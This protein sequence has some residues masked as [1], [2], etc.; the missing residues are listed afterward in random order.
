MLP[1]SLAW[2]AETEAERE[3][4]VVQ[5]VGDDSSLTERNRE[6]EQHENSDKLRLVSVSDAPDPYSPPVAGSLGITAEFEARPTDAG[7]G[8]AR[9]GKTF[10]IRVTVTV[11][12][13]TDACRSASSKMAPAVFFGLVELGPMTPAAMV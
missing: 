8:N 11:S 13:V 9:N 7:A 4:H 5:N 1:A 10:A 12:R 3:D 2:A 6:R